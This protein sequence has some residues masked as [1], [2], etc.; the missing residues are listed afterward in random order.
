MVYSEGV[1]KH[2]PKASEESHQTLIQGLFIVRADLRLINLMIRLLTGTDSA[3]F[4][5]QIHCH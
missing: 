1:T 3:F 4:L 5:L 2:L